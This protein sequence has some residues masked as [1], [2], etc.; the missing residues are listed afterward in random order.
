MT[1]PGYDLTLT[2]ELKPE[3]VQLFGDVAI[4]HYAAA[5]VF[6]FGDGTTKGDGEWRKFTRDSKDAD[7]RH[8]FW[9]RSFCSDAIYPANFAPRVSSA[10]A[11]VSRRH[12]ALHLGQTLD[13]RTG[14]AD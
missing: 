1:L 2:Y 8:V 3:A 6:D 12:D 9:R 13:P 5:Y 7:W 10:I 14:V 11:S 4:V